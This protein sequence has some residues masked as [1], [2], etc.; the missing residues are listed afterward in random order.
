LD[1]VDE[2]EREEYRRRLRER[3]EFEMQAKRAEKEARL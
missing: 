3:Q 2:E 1:V